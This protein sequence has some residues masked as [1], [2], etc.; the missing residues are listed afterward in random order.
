V[1]GT[2]LGTV[3]S[4]HATEYATRKS[5]IRE[6]HF[7]SAL[8][9]TKCSPASTLLQIGTNASAEVRWNPLSGR[10]CRLTPPYGTLPGV[11][12]SLYC[13]SPDGNSVQLFE[14][15]S[16]YLRVHSISELLRGCPAHIKF[17]GLIALARAGAE[18]K[19]SKMFCMDGGKPDVSGSPSGGEVFHGISTVQ[20]VW[21]YIGPNER[22]GRATA[23]LS[24]RVEHRQNPG[25]DN[26]ASP[27]NL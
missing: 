21:F 22:P 12:V 5:V 2:K 18:R 25:S 7:P 17:L 10:A 26:K 6:L 15:Q 24:A 16:A 1:V 11:C 13:H 3:G 20:G 14:K 19:R 4:E 8:F 9:C 23:C 27:G